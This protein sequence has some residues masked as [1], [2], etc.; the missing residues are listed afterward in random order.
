MS[1]EG[2]EEGGGHKSEKK[3]KKS[4][5][6][7][8]VT[9]ESMTVNLADSGTEHFMQLGIDLRVADAHVLDD[10]KLHL[11]EIRNG[12]LLLLS[13]KR[14]QDLGSMEGKNRLRAEIRE[15]VNK[16]LGVNTP[17]GPPVAATNVEVVKE[18]HAEPA[19]EA[20]GEVAKDSQASSKK[21]EAFDEDAGVVD[22]LLTSMVIQ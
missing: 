12:L 16:P 18:A 7:V 1:A 2:G 13:S 14:T 9:L 20:H 4:E 8:F 6:P 19:K 11:P 5:K 15:V 17:A 22:V 10:I 21:S 3:K